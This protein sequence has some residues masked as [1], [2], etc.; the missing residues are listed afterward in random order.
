MASRQRREGVTRHGA[1]FEE[2]EDPGEIL[3]AAHAE[4]DDAE[5]GR[6]HDTARFAPPPG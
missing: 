3:R 2:R 5:V 4:S 1:G 6:F